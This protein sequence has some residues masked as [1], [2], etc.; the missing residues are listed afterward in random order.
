M[1]LNRKNFFNRLLIMLVVLLTTGYTSIAQPFNNEWIDFDKTYYKFKVGADGIYRI[2]AASLSTIGLNTTPAEHFRLYRN[3][4][5]VPLF[6]SVNAGALPADGYIEFWGLANDGTT[7]RILYREE[8]FQHRTKYNLH[9]DTAIY[10]LTVEPSL[11]NKRFTSVTNDVTSNTLP[12]EPYF[13]YKFAR[14]FK[15]RLNPGFASD[16]EQYV[17]SSSYDKGEFF[18]SNEIRQ[19]ITRTD[20]QSN[21]R[22][23]SGGPDATLQFGAFGNT[24]K[25]ETGQGGTEWYTVV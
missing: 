4:V 11:P 5:E 14:D 10:F 21:L 18:S 8:Q 25:N 22:P 19:R 15:E 12:A 7:D 20:N 3:G 6:T 13:I 1:F 16:L 24:K 23:F 2:P 17:F 9:V